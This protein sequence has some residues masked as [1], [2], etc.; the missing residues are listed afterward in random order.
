MSICLWNLRPSDLYL[1]QVA[2]NY[3]IHLG[4][5]KNTV[6][7]IVVLEEII[8]CA[9]E[10]LVKNDQTDKPSVEKLINDLKEYLKQCYLIYDSQ[11]VEVV[12]LNE[13][14]F[15]EYFDDREEF[16][17]SIPDVMHSRQRG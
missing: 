8:N 12:E 9:Q 13:P 3:T 7:A 10:D 11:P 2:K 5:M 17:E 15:V 4:N 1:L 6:K 14:E 16:E